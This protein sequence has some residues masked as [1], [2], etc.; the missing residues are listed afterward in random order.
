M[1]VIHQNHLPWSP[2]VAPSI[3]GEAG[4]Q[5]H[6]KTHGLRSRTAV[7]KRLV[8]YPLGQLDPV[9]ITTGCTSLQLGKVRQLMGFV[10]SWYVMAS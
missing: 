6:G 2:P 7:S 8:V 5:D 4:A 10:S 1:V 9:F 3:R